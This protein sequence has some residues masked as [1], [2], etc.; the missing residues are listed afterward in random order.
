MDGENAS[1]PSRRSPFIWIPAVVV[2]ALLV[3]LGFLVSKRYEPPPVIPADAPADVF[4]AERARD[5]AD[6]E[7]VVAAARQRVVASAAI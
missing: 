5:A 1:Q 4:S 7:V 3:A 2:A 6:Q